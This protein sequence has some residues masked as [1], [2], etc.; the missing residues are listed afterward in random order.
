MKHV[1]KKKKGPAS[2]RQGGQ[3]AMTAV[4]LMLFIMLAAVFGVTSLALKEAKVSVEDTKSRF[5]FFASEAGVDDAIYRLKRN[6]NITS[7][8][9]LLLNG[10]SATTT[11][12]TDSFGNDIIRAVGKFANSFRAV[13]ASVSKGEGVDFN[14]AVQIG[15]GG[16]VM[17]SNST[18]A[19]NVYSNGAISGS[20]NSQITGDAYAVTTISS[21]PT[22]SGTR[23]PNSLPQTFPFVDADYWRTQ[24]NTNNDPYNG[25]MTISN[26]SN[27]G[28]RRINGDL[29]IGGNTTVTIKGA[30]YVTGNLTLNSNSVLNLDPAFGSQGTVIIVDGTITLNSNVE[31]NPTSAHPKGYIML[32][33]VSNSS[34][35]ISLNS[36]ADSAVL[37][38]PNGNISISSNATAVSMT[39]YQIT[40]NSNASINYDQ[41]LASA[42]FSGGPS[43]SWNITSWQEVVP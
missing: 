30:I 31:V 41:G 26:D 15:Q 28:P 22:V 27:L 40:L 17:N 14:Y 38:A 5:T 19:G 23:N 2:T 3:A 33:T 32:Y 1:T 4:I 18:V 42:N 24:A 43:G 37:F 7:S 36:N 13:S 29:T 20:S 39:A 12:T 11:V 9:S 25:N 8:F 35:A 10:A 21:P 16:L 34:S 6:K